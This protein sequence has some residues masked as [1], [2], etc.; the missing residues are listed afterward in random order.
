VLRSL[1]LPVP[2]RLMRLY[3]Q[4]VS[5]VMRLSVSI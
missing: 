3:P 2:Y 1:T 4:R 5:S